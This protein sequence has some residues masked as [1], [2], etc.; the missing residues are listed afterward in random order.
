LILAGFLALGACAGGYTQEELDAAVADAVDEALQSQEN[1]VTTTTTDPTTTTTTQPT[2]TTTRPTT[3]TTTRPT[4]TTTLNFD[5]FSEIGDRDYELMTRQSDCLGETYVIYGHVTQFD[6]ATGAD[7]FRANTA[8]T[9]Q[10]DWFDYDINTILTGSADLFS[11]V[12]NDDIVKMWVQCLGPFEYE[13]TLG[14]TL[15]VPSFEVMQIEV[16][17]TSD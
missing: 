11:N 4:T 5:N 12:V 2:T 1:E 7:G 14:A 9:A 13:S 8:G 15:T 3:T 10:E 16:I 6:S 17:G